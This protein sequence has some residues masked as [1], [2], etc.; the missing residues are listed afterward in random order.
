MDLANVKKDFYTILYKIF[1]RR[2]T[3]THIINLFEK[4]IIV[5]GKADCE[6]NYIHCFWGNLFLIFVCS[7]HPFSSPISRILFVQW[8]FSRWRITIYAI[9]W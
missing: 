5:N 6:Q 8:S 4:T 7:I 2:N 3:H 1:C 9:V